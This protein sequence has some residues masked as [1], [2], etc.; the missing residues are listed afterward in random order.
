MI[1]VVRKLRASVGHVNVHLIL[2]DLYPNRAAMIEMEKASVDGI[3]YHAAPVDASDV[4]EELIGMRTMVCSLHQI[5]FT[6]LIPIVP[7]FLAWDGAV[8]NA[9]TYSQRDLEE[10]LSSMHF[11]SFTWEVGAIKN[12]KLPG[13]MTYILGL[14]ISS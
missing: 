12:P 14:P 3:S 9:R 6:Y 10:L 11:P 8:S 2:T 5:V 4:P 13:S 1:D 7:L